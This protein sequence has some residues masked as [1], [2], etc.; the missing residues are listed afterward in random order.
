MGNR[1]VERIQRGRRRD[2]RV[3]LQ[4]QLIA[5][6]A[7]PAGI[8]GELDAVRKE[9]LVAPAGRL[10]GVLAVVVHAAHQRIDVLHGAAGEGAV[11]V[12]RRAADVQTGAV[13]TVPA[14]QVDLELVGGIFLRRLRMEHVER[15]DPRIAGTCFQAGHHAVTLGVAGAAQ[16][17]DAIGV[18]GAR[19][20]AGAPASANRLP[21]LV[22][23][24]LVFLDRRVGMRIADRE[25]QLAVGALAD[26]A[27]V[28][29]VAIGAFIGRRAQR[30]ALPAAADR[31]HSLVVIQRTHG[32]HVHGA[33]QALP[34][35]RRVGRLV[36]GDAGHQLGRVLV[37]LDAAVVA[38]ADQLAAVEQGGGEIRRQ[39][40]HAEH[41]R[42]TS[43]ALRRHARQ[44]CDGLGDG[45]VGQLADIFGRYRFDN[46]VRLLLDVD[47]A[48]DTTA[49]TG[50]NDRIKVLG[51]IRLLFCFGCRTRRGGSLCSLLC[52]HLQG[53]HHGCGGE[54]HAQQVS[55]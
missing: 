41:L 31:H 46:R 4:V 2:L 43:D 50:D 16:G 55:L 26:V 34:H 11:A 13:A 6:G 7:R 32:A 25:T 1:Q 14:A 30:I 36:E 53:Q 3:V 21:R 29:A 28:E 51:V 24:H 44:A 49:D 23:A 47:G 17:L 37:E 42:T 33:G 52:L 5:L 40:A 38:G 15:A 22:Q 19:R 18:V 45:D 20:H 48:F 10:D 39:A 54:R 27:D 35:Q 9:E 12:H 8:G